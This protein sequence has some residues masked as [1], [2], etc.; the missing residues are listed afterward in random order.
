MMLKLCMILAISLI[1]CSTQ[2]IQPQTNPIELAGK[3]YPTNISGPSA[4]FVKRFLKP[5]DGW[6]T[7]VCLYTVFGDDKLER[8]YDACPDK[9]ALTKEQI[10]QIRVSVQQ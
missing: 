7:Q 8:E 6:F 4:I 2:T 9:I 3:P 1:G 10:S 5:K